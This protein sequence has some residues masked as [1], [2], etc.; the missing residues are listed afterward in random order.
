MVWKKYASFA[1]ALFICSSYFCN[2]YL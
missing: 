1:W 2:W